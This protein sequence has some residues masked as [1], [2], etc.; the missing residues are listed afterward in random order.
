MTWGSPSSGGGR[1]WSEDVALELWVDVA[2]NPV[3]IR[4]EG[5]LDGRTASNLV[6]VVRE[7]IGEGVRAF[8]LRADALEIVPPDGVA[9][10]DELERLVR[11]SGGHVAGAGR[12]TVT[13]VVS[14]SLR[15]GET[16]PT[17]PVP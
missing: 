16:E 1:W 14:A 8:E 3:V 6:A 2:Q 17:A 11:R 10:L 12:S 7:L 15:R 13:P 4:L 9:V 5:T